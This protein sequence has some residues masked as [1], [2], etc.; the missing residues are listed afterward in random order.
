MHLSVVP[1]IQQ[2]VSSNILYSLSSCIY[3]ASV[4]FIE[5]KQEF[6]GMLYDVIQSVIAFF[7]PLSLLMN[8][9][10]HI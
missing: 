6:G 1:D 2:K 9:F 10:G 3:C 8:Q 4:I 7:P 5:L